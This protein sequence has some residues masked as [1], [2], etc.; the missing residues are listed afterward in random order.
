MI[1]CTLDVICNSGDIRLVGGNNPLEGRVEVCFYNQW[2]TV[3]DSFWGNEE[4]RVVC[5]QL[6]YSGSSE[7]CSITV[8]ILP[9]STFNH[10]VEV[11]LSVCL[12]VCMCTCTLVNDVH[13]TIA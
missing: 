13:F 4:A 1:I 10:S 9:Y 6:G 5:R 2:G 11:Y 7:T 3:C 12:F 8:C